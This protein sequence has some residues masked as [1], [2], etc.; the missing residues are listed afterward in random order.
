VITIN[1]IEPN[2]A[3]KTVA[4]EPGLSLM[5]VARMNGVEGIVA[6]C[7]GECACATCHVHIGAVWRER[8]GPRSDDET[9]LLEFAK[10]TSDDSRLSCQIVVT[11]DLDGLEVRIPEEQY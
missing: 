8:L 10:G 1:F 2:G 4:A 11:E 6:D 5:E 9:D 3:E 7:G